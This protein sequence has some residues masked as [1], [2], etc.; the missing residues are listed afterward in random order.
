[1]KNK[2]EI[3]D[4]TLRDGEQAPDNT[5]SPDEKLKIA[6]KLEEI[7][8][9]IIEAGFPTSSKED[10]KAVELISEKI[11]KPII[12]GLA[13]CVKKDIDDCVKSL[14]KA[15]NKCLH[16]FLATS[17]LHL[18]KKLRINRKEAL[19]TIEENINYSK[20]YFNKIIFSAEDATRTNRDFLIEVYKKAYDLGVDIVN[21]ADTT[22]YSHP[23][24]IYKLI[25]SIKKEIPGLK[26][27]IHC[28]NDLG[29]ATA[30]TLSAVSAGVEQVQTTVNGIGERAGNASFEEVVLAFEIR[31]DFFKKE[32]DLDFKKIQELSNLVYEIVGRKPSHEKA[33]VGVNAFRHEA[34]IHI[35]GILKDPKTYEII[36]PDLVARKRELIKGRHSGNK[37]SSK[38]DEE[39]KNN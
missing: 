9:D 16:L 3:F 15:K 18:D 35:D 33:I 10:F 38:K 36:D 27:S 8:V 19:N 32:V 13:R 1:M 31:K 22:G 26:L 34:G 2:I 20:K 5:M 29:L 4:T 7:G 12:C 24:E 39:R 11:K 6:K 37:S 14:D 30:N 23:D 21:V 28:H 25:K 17:D